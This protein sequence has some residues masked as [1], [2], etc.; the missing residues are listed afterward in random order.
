[1]IET[2]DNDKK[3]EAEVVFHM[4]PVVV[5]DMVSIRKWLGRKPLLKLNTPS[6]GRVVAV[7]RNR[8]C[9]SG[10]MVRVKLGFMNYITLD[11]NWVKVI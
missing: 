4:S 9:S 6:A 10:I 8:D 11:S 5:G 1:M 3:D 7:W 2:N